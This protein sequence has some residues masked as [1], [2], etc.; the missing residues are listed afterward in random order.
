VRASTIWPNIRAAT[1]SILLNTY[2]CASK[3]TGGRFRAPLRLQG[4]GQGRRK[5][6][7]PGVSQRSARKSLLTGDS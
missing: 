5:F 4:G 7:A 2:N 1:T 6:D 3:D